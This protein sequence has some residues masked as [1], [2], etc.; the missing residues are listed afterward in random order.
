MLLL[1]PSGPLFRKL[2]ALLLLLLR[3]VAF[4]F[5]SL[6]AVG[7]ILVC[8]GLLVVGVD[9]LGH[10]VQEELC[11][12]RPPPSPDRGAG[13]SRG[14]KVEDAPGR[15]VRELGHVDGDGCPGARSGG[16]GVADELVDA[17]R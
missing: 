3:M 6:M 12:L 7:L 9:V 2:A 1:V 13:R 17:A 8:V 14:A 11:L 16:G 10:S 4:F 5:A 15:K